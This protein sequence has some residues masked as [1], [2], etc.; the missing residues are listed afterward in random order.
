MDFIKKRLDKRPVMSRVVKYLLIAIG[1]AVGAVGFQ[2]FMQPN[3]IVSGG[4]YNAPDPELQEPL[5]IED[6]VDFYIQQTWEGGDKVANLD[7]VT[8]LCSN[9]LD[10]LHWLE[11]MGMEFDGTITQGVGSLYRRTHTAVMPN[12]T[13]YIKTFEDNLS[14]KDNVTIIMETAGKSLITDDNGAVV[15]VIA[16]AK[17]GRKVTLHASK[18]VVLAT[19]G[20]AGNVEMRVKYCQGE[21]WPNLGE[22][23]ITSNMPAIT[24]D[25]IIMAQEAGADL[26]DMDQIQLLQVCNPK[27]GTTSG[28]FNAAGVQGYIRSDFLSFGDETAVAAAPAALGEQLVETAKQYLGTPYVWGGMSESGFDCSGFVNYV[29]D[30]YGVDLERVAQSIYSKNGTYVEKSDLRAGDLVFFGYSGTSIT[31]VG[32][33]IGGG[34]FIHASSGSG[35]VVITELSSNYYTRMYVGAKR[36]AE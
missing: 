25:G 30:A 3:S 16:E 24:G 33:Y 14:A 34:Q 28:H 17:D 2:F 35:K 36:I 20:F 4:I 31:H 11:S 7:L 32:M 23:L 27:N 13:G 12:G 29:Y 8:V 21:K 5:G 18:G 22:G 1:S 6:S 26:V 10:G 19:G 9:A 15:G